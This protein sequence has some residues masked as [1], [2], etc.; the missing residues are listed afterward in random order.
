MKH[1]TIKDVAKELNCSISTV[2]RA[3]NDK[4]DIRP[5]TRDKILKVAREMGYSPNPIARKLTQKQSFN[6]GVVVPEFINSFF[7]NVIIGM[8]K[9]FAKNGYQVLIMQSNEN[10]ENELKNLKT[11]VDNFVDGIIISFTKETNN[12]D[13]INQLIERNYPIVLF[14]RVHNSLQVSKV[15]FDDYKMSFFATEH[16]I[17]QGKKNLVHLSGPKYLSLSENRK[18]GF[19]DACRK[20]KIFVSN[21]SIIETKFLLK[22]GIEI[23]KK[24]HK[25]NKMPDAFVCVN[26]PTAVGVIKGLKKYGY[27]IPDDV[28]VIGF[29]ETEMASLIEPKLSSV[30]QPLEEM[31]ATAAELLLE[32]IESKTFISPK[33]I[34][35]NGE[36]VYRASSNKKKPKK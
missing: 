16:I 1:I 34:V 6:I 5:E 33:T 27:K 3:H 19:L 26:D 28:A 22:N 30:K 8:Q 23:V 7:P 29:S 18:K 36:L 25:S 9:V 10:L 32:Q 21:N 15:V 20:H 14:N 13:Y 24:F 35:M 17:N 2:S 12:I 4:Y 11:L 31:G